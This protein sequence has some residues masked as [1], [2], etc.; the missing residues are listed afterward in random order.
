MNGYVG[1]IIVLKGQGKDN[2]FI[3]QS[4]FLT[5]QPKL[6]ILRTVTI[7]TVLVSTS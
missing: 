3:Q 6:C 7:V 4:I 5:Y 2:Y 1:M